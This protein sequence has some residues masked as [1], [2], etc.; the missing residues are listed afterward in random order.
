[1]AQIINEGPGL[2]ALLGSSLGTGLGA[3]FNQ[4]A[5]NKLNQL[6]NRQQATQSAKGLAALGIPMEQAHQIAL[7][8][9]ELQSVILKNYLQGAESAGLDQA[10]AGVLG[11]GAEEV[12]AEEQQGLQQLL[13]QPAQQRRVLPSSNPLLDAIEEYQARQAPQQPTQK[14]PTP[15]QLGKE[16]KAP[17]LQDVLLRPRLSPEHK[18]KVAALQQQR[19]MHQEKLS[20]KQQESVDKET[21]PVYDEI[22]KKAKAAKENSIRLDKLEKLVDEEQISSPIFSRIVELTSNRPVI[23]SLFRFFENP[24]DEEFKKLSADFVKNAKEYFGSRLTD[25]DLKVF[26]QTVPSLTQTKEGKKRVIKNLKSFGEIDLLK[27]KAADQIISQNGGIRPRNFD[28]LVEERIAPQVDAIAKQFNEAP[29]IK[30]GTL[31]S[32]FNKI[33]L[34]QQIYRGLGG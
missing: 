20:A 21:K 29:D 28:A 15:T 4:L 17:T 25:A 11:T 22:A 14:E 10:L 23:G 16:K 2:G 8:P 7:L 26:M 27:K 31:G 3:G 19:Q 34:I 32:I 24:A 1:M 18:L 30:R 9:Q 13:Q 33:P 12:Q 6:L 5:Q